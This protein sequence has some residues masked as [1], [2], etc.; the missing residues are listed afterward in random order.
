[1]V[2]AAGYPG[3]KLASQALKEYL[4]LLRPRQQSNDRRK[5]LFAFL[6]SSCCSFASCASFSRRGRVP[7]NVV[8]DFF[9]LE[10]HLVKL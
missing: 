2:G 7:I 3:S 1:M 6:L 9:F 5:P 8:D 10:V 4:L